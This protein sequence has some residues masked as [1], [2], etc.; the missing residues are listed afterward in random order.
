MPKY[1][2]MAFKIIAVVGAIVFLPLSFAINYFGGIFPPTQAQKDTFSTRDNISQ[3]VSVFLFFGILY[4][5]GWYIS[6]GKNK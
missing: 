6:R 1:I 3:I 4:F 2:G 5:L